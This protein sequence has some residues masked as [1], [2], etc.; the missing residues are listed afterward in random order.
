ML[1]NQ[2]IYLDYAAA[3]P[4]SKKALAAMAPYFSDKFY[5]PSAAYLAANNARDDFERARHQL[6]QSIGARPAEIILTA[7]ATESIN[8][9]LNVD[10]EILASQI[11]HP[12][13]LSCAAGRG[14][15]IKVDKFGRVDLDDLKNKLTDKVEIVSVG[16]ANSEIGTIQPLKQIAEIIEKA[17]ENRRA[18]GVETPLYLHSDA[19]A[20]AGLLDLNVARLGVDLL[21]LNA[22]KCYGPKQVGL[23]YVKADV[24]L[25]PLIKGGGQERNLRSGTENVAGAI[26]FAAALDEASRHR[27]SEFKRLEKLRDELK[28]FLAKE[29]G[30]P[31]DDNFQTNSEPI[32]DGQIKFNGDPKHSLPNILN[33][34]LKNLDGERALFALDEAGVMVAT[35]SA[36]AAN[37]GLRSHVLTAIGLSD[38]LA[39]GSLRISL[40]RPTTDA[41]IQ[42]VKPILQKVLRQQLKFGQMR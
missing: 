4:L 9:A 42:R 26:G 3:T 18:R 39:D 22:A 20:A 2:P 35:G 14:D 41:E 12:A 5:N 27:Q 40:G 11:E 38:N 25:K 31:A 6:A 29:F 17:R 32:S 33:F 23:L 37:K 30:A 36:C 28:K 7:G 21:T 10:G 13:V 8:L 15:L 24:K 34:S 19:S 16:L 1:V